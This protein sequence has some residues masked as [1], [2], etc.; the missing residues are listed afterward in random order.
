MIKEIREKHGLSKTQ[1]SDVSGIP[2]R[3]IQNWEAGVRKCPEYV[4]KLLAFY[5]ENRKEN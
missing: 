1:L 3:T 4:E 2:Y 5:L